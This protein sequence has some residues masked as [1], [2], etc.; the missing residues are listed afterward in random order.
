MKR[1]H[2]IFICDYNRRMNAPI[3][4][5]LPC[6]KPAGRP[7]ASEVEER[8]H[9]LIHTAGQL[10]LK[11][12]YSKV[13]LE[14]I[15][16]EAHVAVRTIYV[17]FGGKAGL[18]K[19]VLE[20]NREMYFKIHEIDKDTRPLREFI[21]DFSLHFLEM[22]TAPQALQVQR[23]VIAEAGSNP[24]LATTFFETGPQQ[25]RAM[26][27]R[28]FAR[29]DIRAQLRDDVAAEL[30]PMHLLN[31]VMGDQFTRFLI[32]PEPVEQDE[33]VRRL[34]QRLELFYRSVLREPN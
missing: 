25:T 4:E 31:C 20:N 21:D 24:E 14:T 23:M 13:S 2:F 32:D 10:F 18:F 30:L 9:Q 19:A 16:R 29:P 34:K 6:C 26:L 11:H 28:F 22:I 33:I 27:T 3:E 8:L 5:T 15:A 12:G 17:K 1:L 7:R